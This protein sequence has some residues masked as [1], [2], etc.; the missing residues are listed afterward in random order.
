M[1]IGSII[2]YIIIIDIIVTLL[3]DKTNKKNKKEIKTLK[4][5][6]NKLHKEI[7]EYSLINLR[8]RDKLKEQSFILEHRIKNNK[9]THEIENIKLALKR[10]MMYTHPDKGGNRE[11]FELFNSLYKEYKDI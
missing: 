5:E 4:D 9:N 2:V 3:F 10:A 7:S 1:N 11:E 6:N 8:L